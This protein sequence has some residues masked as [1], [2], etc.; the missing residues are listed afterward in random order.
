MKG[1]NIESGTKNAKNGTAKIPV[2]MTLLKF[3]SI[4][5]I[6]PLYHGKKRAQNG[7]N[8]YVFV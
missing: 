8:I 3:F 4:V 7:N 2:R 5:F 6:A 1:K